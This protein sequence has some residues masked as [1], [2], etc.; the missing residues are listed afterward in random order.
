MDAESVTVNVF[1]TAEALEALTAGDIK[2][3]IDGSALAAGES[4]N[5]AV[6]F[7]NK[8]GV[9]IQNTSVAI[10]ITSASADSE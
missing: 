8:E 9:T 3:Y 1:G 4:Q 10:T 5:V 2:G 7:E 6:Q